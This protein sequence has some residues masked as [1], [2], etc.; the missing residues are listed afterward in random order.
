MKALWVTNLLFPEAQ[1]LLT[2]KRGVVNGSGGWLSSSAEALVTN[3]NINLAVVAISNRVS[4]LTRLEGK[5]MV[6]YVMPAGKGNL[7]INKE[8]IPIWKEIYSDFQPDLVHLHG[9]ELSHGWSLL[10]ALPEA[11]TVI[12]IQGLMS[13]ICKYYT[14]GMSSKDIRCNITLRDVVHDIV[15]RKVMS[16]SLYRKKKNYE[17]KGRNELMIYR[18]AKAV[19][20]RTEWDKANVLAINPKLDYYVCNETLRNEFYSGQW[21]YD[22]CEPHTVFLSQATYPF[23]GLHMIIKA[24][25]LIFQEFPDMRVVVAGVN[26]LGDEGLKGWLKQTGYSK[27][28]KKL[29]KQLGVEKERITFTGPLD[30][31]GMKAEFLKCNVFISPS[32]IE[33]S[34]N[35]VC[36]AQMLGVPVVASYVGGTSDMIPDRQCG[37]LYRFEDVEML[38]YHIKT[39]F[40]E[41]PTFDGSHEMSIAHQRHNSK[42]NQEQLINIYKRIIGNAN[43]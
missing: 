27:Y 31:E 34:P 5:K 11:K 8:Y 20:G 29:M 22:N 4:T 19:I 28:V 12:S 6:Y 42:A 33:N 16:G 15:R 26:V 37:V 32:G 2:G 17:I 38:A 41:S 24:L 14:Y 10:E 30:A 3:E 25:P 39:I 7:R 18:K 1:E 9:T 43:D 40:R 23:K 36:E 35:S 21:R 13:Q